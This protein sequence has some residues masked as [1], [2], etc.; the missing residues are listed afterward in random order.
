MIEKRRQH[1]GKHLEDSDDENAYDDP[2]ADFLDE[3]DLYDL[4][5]AEAEGGDDKSDDNRRSNQES[6]AEFP[7]IAILFHYV[8]RFQRIVIQ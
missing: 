7:F 6:F 5:E 4:A 2:F 8:F 3:G 1:R